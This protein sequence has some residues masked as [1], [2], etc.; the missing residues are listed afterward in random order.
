MH[1]VTGDLR[2]VAIGSWYRR[3][4][5]IAFRAFFEKLGNA[6]PGLGNL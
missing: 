4:L 5:A 1:D 2:R 6:L 3:E